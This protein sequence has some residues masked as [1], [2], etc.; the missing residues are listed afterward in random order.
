MELF[1]AYMTARP[2]DLV[3]FD[4]DGTLMHSMDCLA[5]WIHRAV[6]EHCPPSVTPA[7]ITGAF[8]P[9]EE[10][11][12]AQFVPKELRKASLNT[13]Y[14][15]YEREHDRVYVYP[16][17]NELLKEIHKRGIPMA[18]CTGKSRRAVQISLDLLGWKSLF[19]VIITGDDTM[20]F[21]PDPEGLNLI[22]KKTPA[23]PGRTIFIGDAAAD[24]GAA[25]NA[26]IISGLANWG[27]HGISPSAD[28]RP[29]HLF[30]TPQSVITLLSGQVPL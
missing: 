8:G 24:T 29:D 4:M 25:R 10:K 17:I 2:F 5:D 15:L 19:P 6:K 13:Y 20:R 3:I 28:A 11:I 26:G 23:M 1:K 18:L 14:D 21:K 9:T 12:I 22:L 7:T 16:G 27:A 30:T